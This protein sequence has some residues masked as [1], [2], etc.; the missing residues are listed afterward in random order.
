MKNRLIAL[1]IGTGCALQAACSGHHPRCTT[2]PTATTYCLQTTAEIPAF[3]AQQKIDIAFKEQ[4]HTLIADLNIDAQGVRLIGLTPFG[5]TLIH[6]QDD[7]RTI[8]TLAPPVANSPKNTA[9]YLAPRFDPTI[10]IALIQLALWPE[11]ALRIGL[12]APLT[13]EESPELRRIL[14]RDKP[15]LIIRHSDDMNMPY[16]TLHISMPDIALEIDIQTLPP[17]IPTDSAR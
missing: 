3:S 5:Q 8:T 11:K 10:L 17:P 9:A 7:N 6:I 16:Q 13:L 15:I 2:L 14:N 12:Q 4:R 1:L